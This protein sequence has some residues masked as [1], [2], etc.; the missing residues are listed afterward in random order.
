[1]AKRM[2]AMG[3]AL[4]LAAGGCSG[5]SSGER[6]E[7]S[8]AIVSVA[9]AD[10]AGLLS[11]ADGFDFRGTHWRQPEKV[12]VGNVNITIYSEADAGA[13]YEMR[14]Q[15]EADI[16]N[17][18]LLIE[19]KQAENSGAAP[20]RPVE[21]DFSLRLRP[22]TTH[23]FYLFGSPESATRVHSSAETGPIT[24]TKMNEQGRVDN[25][26]L[27]A[28]Y[29]P[30]HSI[31]AGEL[32]DSVSRRQLAVCANIVD[33]Q[34]GDRLR[35]AVFSRLPDDPPLR[36]MLLGELAS[37]II[38]ATCDSIAFPVIAK[39]GKRGFEYYEPLSRV[40]YSDGI[41]TGIRVPY[42]PFSLSQF[43]QIAV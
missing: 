5:G 35:E 38:R 14:E 40:L 28:P 31:L 32:D 39:S 21:A 43:E 8:P 18:F 20:D 27:L 13:T 12:A 25:V 22:N 23:T 41:S 7:T 30:Q 19:A 17:T 4:A 24:G 2:A 15:L 9:E 33:V 6:Q 26:S 1:M 16:R 42:V 10:P 36:A 34:I 11:P 3:V 29:P 37:D